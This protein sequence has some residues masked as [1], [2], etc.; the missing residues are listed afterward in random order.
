MKKQWILWLFASVTM[1]VAQPALSGPSESDLGVVKK[2]TSQSLSAEKKILIA[3]LADQKLIEKFVDLENAEEQAN[4]LVRYKKFNRPCLIEACIQWLVDID[5]KEIFFLVYNLLRQKEKELFQITMSFMYEEDLKDFFEIPVQRSTNTSVTDA[6]TMIVMMCAKNGWGEEVKLYLERVKKSKDFYHV[7]EWCAES[8]LD[9]I[10][11]PYIDI[12][13]N[14]RI[15]KNVLERLLTASSTAFKKEKAP[16]LVKEVAELKPVMAKIEEP[17]F[18]NSEEIKS[19]PKKKNKKKKKA[20]ESQEVVDDNKTIISE[21]PSSEASFL[22]DGKF[23]NRFGGRNF[24]VANHEELE[25]LVKSPHEV[26][27]ECVRFWDNSV[28]VETGFNAVI[29]KGT[30]EDMNLF[31]EHSGHH[32][33][34]SFVQYEVLGKKSTGTINTQSK[35]YQ[36]LNQTSLATEVFLNDSKKIRCTAFLLE[37]LERVSVAPKYCIE[38]L[39]KLLQSFKYVE[40]DVK[41]DQS[42]V[43]Y[44]TDAPI[45]C[46]SI[47]KK[48]SDVITLHTFQT[49]IFICALR[50]DGQALLTAYPVEKAVE[51]ENLVNSMRA[52]VIE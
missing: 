1:H 37:K 27:Q 10:V 16:E 23:A 46:V 31:V 48:G 38:Y 17:K 12:I 43:I 44:Q 21:V 42:C 9:D 2:D 18:T 19:P 47:N 40:E 39:A 35:E 34:S 51:T 29:A 3:D 26:V 49:D 4:L 5:I 24:D 8:G 6:G 36:L 20:K 7:I 45:S 33:I 13:K 32:F 14:E 50:K 11:K 25:D 52:L 15:K 22:T 30:Q 28:N 41:E